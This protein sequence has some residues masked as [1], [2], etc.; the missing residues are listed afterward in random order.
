MDYDLTMI[1][2]IDIKHNA[3]TSKDRTGIFDKAPE[4]IISEKTG[5]RILQWCNQTVSSDEVKMKI[6]TST[7]LS[8][9]TSL[10]NAHPEYQTSLL[11]FFTAKKATLNNNLTTQKIHANGS[12]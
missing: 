7:S 3:H 6:E 5:E 10:Y 1:F 9:L 11:S 12:T 8:E 4:F 2:E